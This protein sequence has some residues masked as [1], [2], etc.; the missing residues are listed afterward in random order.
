MT[1]TRI[2]INQ[3]EPV[4]QG[5]MA[6]LYPQQTKPQGVLQYLAEILF[7]TNGSGLQYFVIGHEGF[8]PKMMTDYHRAQFP[9][10]RVS[11]YVLPQGK[12][13]RKQIQ[14]VLGTFPHA[15][16]GTFS[17]PDAEVEYYVYT[18]WKCN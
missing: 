16:V 9:N 6:D 5:I 10:I 13:K 3:D 4:L 11:H 15:K 7:G 18:Y 1:D 12:M 17:E 8:T 2:S 14:R